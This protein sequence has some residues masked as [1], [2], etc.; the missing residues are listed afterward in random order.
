MRNIF[1]YELRRLLWNKIFFGILAV[2]AGWSWA[3]LTGEVLLGTANTAPF[4]PWSFG[5]YLSRLLPLLCAGEL[6]FLSFFTS[7][8]ERRTRVLTQAA[9][10]DP[11]AYAAVR[12][13]AVLTGTLLLWLA[14][15]GAY[16][17]FC[18][19]LFGWKDFLSLLP[20]ALLVLAP[21]ALFCA[22]AGWRLGR[23]GL[24]CGLMAAVVLL[25]LLPLPDAFGFALSGFFAS[26]PKTLGVLDPPLCVPNGILLNRA[27][28]TVLG[29][30]AFCVP[31]RNGP[32]A[33]KRPRPAGR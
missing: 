5:S 9:P 33:A 22:G 18:A 21:P 25:T 23:T 19:V 8:Q 15:V 20:T 28:W 2:T 32:S 14:A 10:V 24:V 29:A 26:Y 31:R 30:A 1:R 6:F 27:V 17:L 3:L 11:R 16:A 12:C 4:S 13:A 7:G